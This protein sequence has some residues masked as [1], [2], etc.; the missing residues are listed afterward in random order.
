LDSDRKDADC[1]WPPAH[2]R[3]AGPASGLA[4]YLALAYLFLIVY[5]SLAPFAGWRDPGVPA[6]SFLF[7][8][9]PRYV[10]RFDL[11][12]NFAAYLPLGFLSA[13][14]LL[15]RFSKVAAA[16][17]ATSAGVLLSVGMEA[18]QMFLPGRVS[19]HLDVAA[20]G[21][22]ALAGACLAARFGRS[23]AAALGIRRL[24]E[25]WFLSGPVSDLGL[26]LLALWLFTQL[27]PSLPLLENVFALEDVRRQF[28]AAGPARSLSL[29]DSAMVLLNL[30]SIF[31]I[32]SLVSRSSRK[33]IAT[34]CGLLLAAAGIKILAAAAMLKPAAHLQ[35]LAPE[36]AI[37][38]LLGAPIAALLLALNARGRMVACTLALLFGLGLTH[39]HPAGGNPGL[40]LKLFNWHYGHLLNYNGL[41][42]IAADLWPWLAMGFLFLRYWEFIRSAPQDRL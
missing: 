19:Q 37:G 18:L 34:A 29:L 36:V 6:W 16:A 42:K 32:A 5:T 31:L 38:F 2:G 10:T 1:A 33:A 39:I 28:A 14:A 11:F 20:N 8:A 13:L 17:L 4:F 41:A 27:N 22:G 26:A 30:V 9:R 40:A 3:G 25:A 24:R 23:S 7:A 35:W 12:I 21:L 15:P